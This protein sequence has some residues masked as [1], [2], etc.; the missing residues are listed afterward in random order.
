MPFQRSSNPAPTSRWSW[1][2]CARRMSLPR[3]SAPHASAASRSCFRP[4][5]SRYSGQRDRAIRAATVR[6]SRTLDAWRC[7]TR[8]ERQP[9]HGNKLKW[10]PG[11]ALGRLLNKKKNKNKIRI[12]A[13]CHRHRHHSHL[14]PKS[15]PWSS[16]CPPRCCASQTPRR[17]SISIL[18]WTHCEWSV[19]EGYSCRRLSHRL[20]PLRKEVGISHFM[21]YKSVITEHWVG[22]KSEQIVNN[23]TPCGA[24][25]GNIHSREGTR[26][27]WNANAYE[28]FY[29]VM[30]ETVRTF[31][32]STSRKAFSS[33]QNGNERTKN[34]SDCGFFFGRKNF[35]LFDDLVATLSFIK[36]C[37][38][39]LKIFFGDFVEF[40]A[41][42]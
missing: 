32:L 35:R 3:P 20:G 12:I 6:R 15:E 39:K 4:T 19:I 17:S 23:R 28:E 10:S 21:T 24:C 41:L 40:Q 33:A 30:I 9:P 22:D 16:C 8:G 26:G 36:L 5:L 14:Y 18:S 38:L 37:M 27:S 31:A 25:E 34:L 2:R 29:G 1:V 7:R 42:A 13:R 11:T